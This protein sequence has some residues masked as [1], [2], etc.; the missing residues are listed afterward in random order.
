MVGSVSFQGKGHKC[1]ALSREREIIDRDEMRWDVMD[2][3]YSRQ[4]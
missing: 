3:S 4:S 1:G 2:E